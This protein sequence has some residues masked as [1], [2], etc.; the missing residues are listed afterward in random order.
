M[1]TAMMCD[2]GSAI[3]ARSLGPRNNP[4]KHRGCAR[5]EQGVA[6]QS[7]P[8][9]K[10]A[11]AGGMKYR[12]CSGRIDGGG[13]KRRPGVAKRTN[14]SSVSV[15]SSLVSRC[16]HAAPRSAMVRSK[17][18]LVGDQ[19]LRAAIGQDAAHFGEREQRVQR[20]RDASG[21]DDR[22]EPMK[23]LPVVGAI[24]G[25]GLAG[26]ERDR[27]RRKASMEQI[28]SAIRRDEKGRRRSTETSQSPFRRSSSSIRLAT[29]TLRSRA[30]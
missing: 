21:A 23:A 4:A 27:R 19:D 26:T 10:T 11:G 28:R 14:P 12:N 18:R 17:D 2:Q 29:V 6:R 22:Q 16:A 20:N 1:L 30:S 15:S 24:N 3:S 5:P 9:G 8:F 25:D 7:R 13:R